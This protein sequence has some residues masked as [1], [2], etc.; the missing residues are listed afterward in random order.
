MLKGASGIPPIISSMIPSEILAGTS[1]DFFRDSPN[2]LFCNAFRG[3]FFLV[4]PDV[5]P[6]EIVDGISQETHVGAS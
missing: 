4:F 6:Q 1:R 5:V 2:N 3:F